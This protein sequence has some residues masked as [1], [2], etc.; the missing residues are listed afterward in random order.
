MKTLFHLLFLLQA[1]ACCLIAQDSQ[2]KTSV[3]ATPREIRHYEPHSSLKITSLSRIVCPEDD[4]SYLVTLAG[5]DVANSKPDLILHFGSRNTKDFYDPKE[6]TF[7]VFL[8]VSMQPLILSL[9]HD[10]KSRLSFYF[11]TKNGQ[12]ITDQ[13]SAFFK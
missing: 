4:W 6:K 13:V 8:P 12:P 5:S 10:S 9:V 1:L 7:E 11:S 2:Q 3:Q